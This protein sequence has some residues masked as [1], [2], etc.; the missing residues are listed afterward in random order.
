MFVD[1]I[2]YVCACVSELCIVCV[3]AL[4]M[5]ACAGLYR[6]SHTQGMARKWAKVREKGVR[7]WRVV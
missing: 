3:R 2:V 4:Y 6:V 5:C 7:A 1:V